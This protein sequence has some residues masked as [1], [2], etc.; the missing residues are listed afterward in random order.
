MRNLQRSLISHGSTGAQIYVWNVHHYRPFIYVVRRRLR[1]I[2]LDHHTAWDNVAFGNVL[3][4]SSGTLHISASWLA[5]RSGSTGMSIY[6]GFGIGVSG[7]TTG[8]AAGEKYANNLGINL[9][10]A[11]F[12]K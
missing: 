4:I 6:S 1:R 7:I 8:N 9:V 12:S 11:F 2:V 10:F 3:H 5:N